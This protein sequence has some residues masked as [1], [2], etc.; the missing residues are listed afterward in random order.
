MSENA[1][2]EIKRLRIEN[3]ALLAS[4]PHPVKSSSEC[5]V[6][7]ERLEKVDSQGRRIVLEWQEEQGW[8]INVQVD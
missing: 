5:P 4:L 2:E 1:Q 7:Y 8:S 3:E 6:T